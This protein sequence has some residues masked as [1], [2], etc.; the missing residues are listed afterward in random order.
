MVGAPTQISDPTRRLR[1]GNINIIADVVP[2][3][4]PPAIDR[5][6]HV[7]VDVDGECRY[8]FD[9]RTDRSMLPGDI[10]KEV[11]QSS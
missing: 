2:A 1:K 6:G 3:D 10:S 7:G 9:H 4:S 5:V 8:T 11:Q